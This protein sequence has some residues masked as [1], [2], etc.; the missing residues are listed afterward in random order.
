MDEKGHLMY[1][2]EKGRDTV[3]LKGKG[4]HRGGGWERMIPNEIYV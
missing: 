3:E 2:Q 4:E 1:E